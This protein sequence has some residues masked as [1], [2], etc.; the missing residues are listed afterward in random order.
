MAEIWKDIP[1]YEGRYQ[2][3]S[4]GRIRSLDRV[5]IARSKTGKPYSR[6]VKGKI[7]EQIP[8]HSPTPY[9]SVG[10]DDNRRPLVHC[11]V[12][13]AF[14]GPRPI[15]QEVRHLNNNYLD[16]RAE[17]LAYGTHRENM[18][19]STKEERHSHRLSPKE[20]RKIR[21]R[22]QSGETNTSISKDYD[23]SDVVISNIRLGRR[24]KW[25]H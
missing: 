1:G 23:V 6:R 12:A 4:D 22:I 14:L 21:E 7:K 18:A 16:N 5:V 9:L 20:V 3:S 24:Y 11:L 2:A 13:L 10:L 25:V 15:G 8:N 19:D 17:N